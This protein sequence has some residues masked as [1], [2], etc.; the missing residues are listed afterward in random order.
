M[1]EQSALIVSLAQGMHEMLQ[2]VKQL[3]LDAAAAASAPHSS[4]SVASGAQ[5]APAPA[6]ASAPAPALGPPTALSPPPTP[7]PP[8]Q[9]A[10]S[11]VPEEASQ[12]TPAAHGT[13]GAG[14][15]RV[16]GPRGSQSTRPGAGRL[17]SVAEAS[18]GG[19]LAHPPSMDGT[20]D[21]EA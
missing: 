5:Q 19:P 11:I 14:G 8:A 6:Q 17:A 13:V 2:Q 10:V 20:T 9:A 4:D 15:P 3:R 16:M 12:A 21:A 7:T 18:A 1:N